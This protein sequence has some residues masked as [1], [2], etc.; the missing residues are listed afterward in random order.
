MREL[1]PG[2]PTLLTL[3]Q[4][5]DALSISTVALEKK[6]HDGEF[7]PPDDTNW[8]GKRVWRTDTFAAWFERKF[9]ALD[10]PERG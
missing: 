2:T 1:P 3:R 4:I 10:V 8:G 6:I 5:A 7:P 9:P